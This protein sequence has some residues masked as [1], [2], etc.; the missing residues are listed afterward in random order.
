MNERRREL[1]YLLPLLVFV[2][3][4]ALVPAG[5]LFASTL[6]ASGGVAGVRS[7]LADRLDRL[8]IDNSLFQG[9]L[10]A[11]FA[12][13]V[14]YPTG[15]MLGRYRWPGRSAVRSLLLI[16][17][18]LPSLIVVLGVEDLFGPGGTAS[19][20]LPALRVF[21]SGVPGIVGANLLF[22]V[23]LVALFTATGCAGA[24]R[25]LEESAAT[26]GGTPTRVYVDT[27]GRPTW[28]GAAAGGLLTF[29]F[30]A[31]SFAPPLL[32]CGPR[33][34]TVEARIYALDKG[35]ALAPN[36]A[37]VL[38]LLMVGLFLPPT[39]AY[40]ALVGRLR[41]RPGQR[42]S[43]PRPLPWRRPLG[44]A[45]A[46]ITGGV[47]VVEA[48]LL[49][50][51]LYRSVRPVGGG[52]WG[53]AWGS[54]FAPATGARLGIPV[55]GAIGNTLLFAV[56]ATVITLL[57]GIAA[58]HALSRH[59][60]RAGILGLLLFAPL[61]LS[62]VVL[63]FAL[64]QFWRPILGGEGGVWALIIVSQAVLALPFA[65]QSLEI[66]LAGLPSEASDSARTLGASPWTAYLDVDLPRVRD[67]V[68]TAGLF[69]LALGLGEFTATYF[70]VTPQFTTVPVAL[71]DL[72][73]CSRQFAL[74]DTLAG[75]LLVL[76]LAV[77]AALAIGGRR[78]E[79]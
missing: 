52:R 25:E 66:P 61:L 71:Y 57:F 27:W 18:L 26:L 36:A 72:S 13:A 23:P 5:A 43:P 53:G 8:A 2:L 12:L 44:A 78:V 28:V 10:S 54:L 34:Y 73:C 38:A 60:R 15:I 79:L 59:P 63:A 48:A 42:R 62:P 51:V 14:G 64:A 20:L 22:N 1:L 3:L 74:T 58:G 31:L 40:L 30:S 68:I 11:V 6:S 32:L 7:V 65:I 69:A 29:L 19:S 76:S 55:G 16:P 45:L 67:G 47:L 75:L 35:T 17:F 56:G 33:C 77:F 24:S 21:G 70:L 4:F 50:S 37:G 9:G 49:A 41:A 46:A 39:V